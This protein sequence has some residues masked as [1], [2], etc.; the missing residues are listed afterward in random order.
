[1]HGWYAQ[2]GKMQREI[3]KGVLAKRVRSF[4]TISRNRLSSLL[5]FQY[6]STN[7]KIYSIFLC[8]EDINEVLLL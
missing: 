1:M 2:R 4:E 8:I 7:I 5:Y 3:L 6:G